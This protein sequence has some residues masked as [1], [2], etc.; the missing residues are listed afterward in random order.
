MSRNLLA[1][2]GLD[3]DPHDV[4]LFHDQVFVVIDLDLP[5]GTASLDYNKDP[6]QGIA[7]AVFQPDRP[8]TALMERLLAKCTDHLSLLAA[9]ATLERVYDFGAEAFDAIF[10]TLRSA[11]FN[12]RAEVLL[13]SEPAPTPL[14]GE[15]P[16]AAQ[17]TASSTDSLTIEADVTHPAI[18]LITDVYTPSWRAVA[19]PGSV[20]SKYQLLPSNYI[21]RAVPLLAG[22]HHLRVEYVS[23]EFAIGKWISVAASILFLVALYRFRQIMLPLSE[24]AGEGR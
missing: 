20:Q 18:L 17:I 4:T 7:N 8:D 13:E 1:G 10:D 5:F 16:G 15:N 9:P 2:F 24:P 21:L 19:L 12:P 22:H 14:P 3:Q 6:L 11:G 23:R